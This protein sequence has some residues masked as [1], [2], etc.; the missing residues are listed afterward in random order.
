MA[1]HIN[2]HHPGNID[3]RMRAAIETAELKA[4]VSVLER[5]LMGAQS[6]LDAIFTRIAR[7]EVVE[8]HYPDGRVIVVRNDG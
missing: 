8:L 5:Y 2:I 3:N 4:R 6:D 7:G 1:D